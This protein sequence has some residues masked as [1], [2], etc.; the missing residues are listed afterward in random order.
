MITKNEITIEEIKKTLLNAKETQS[1]IIKLKSIEKVLR[2]ASN[3]QAPSKNDDDT[4]TQQLD[5]FIEKLIGIKISIQLNIG[6]TTVS[7]G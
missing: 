2:L 3:L 5:K 6:L 4:I 1:K 7:D